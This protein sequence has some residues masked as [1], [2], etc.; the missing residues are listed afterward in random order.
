MGQRFFSNIFALAIILLGL[1]LVLV[2]IGAVTWS[3]GDWWHYIYPSF[4]ILI[5]LKWL[6]GS[7][8]GVN[9]FATP[10]FLVVFGGLLLL[11]QFDLIAFGFWDLYKLWP[12]ILMFIGLNILGL[13]KRKS[14]FKFV[15]D[16]D[17]ADS[18]TTGPSGDEAFQDFENSEFN[19]DE[20]PTQAH[21]RSQK[22]L[23]GD[24]TY[25][26]PNWKVEPIHLW[27]AIGEHTMDFTKAF[28][29]EK[30]TPITIHGLAGDITIILPDHVDFRVIAAVKAGDLVVVDQHTSGL[31]RAQTYQTTGYDTAIRKLTFDL[32]LKAGSI[33]V[34][35][36]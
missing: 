23:I 7:I 26:K 18:F 6:Y 19:Q 2:N 20:D 4:F 9:G 35:R 30:E 33:R 13:N 1:M 12:L 28:I 24:F 3:F 15:Y 14:K 32:K 29:P 36:I 31:N 22:V 34:N 27:N 17:D 11:N 21:H 8:K 16:S 5:G 25:D 10:L